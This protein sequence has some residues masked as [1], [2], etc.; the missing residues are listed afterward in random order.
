VQERDGRFLAYLKL[1]RP[2]A[3]YYTPESLPDGWRRPFSPQASDYTITDFN[4]SGERYTLVRNRYDNAVNF[5]DHQLGRLL[6]HLDGSGLAKDTAIV[7]VADHGEAWGQRG[8]FAHGFQNYEEFLEV[9]LIVHRPGQTAEVD[10]RMVSLMDV[11][12]TVLDLLGLPPYANHQGGSLLEGEERH[13]FWADSNSAARLTTLQLGAWKYTENRVTAEATLFDM[14][15]DPG[16]RKNLA[17]DPSAGE[18]RDALR[19]L[20][21]SGN[22]QQLAWAAA[23]RASPTSAL[24]GG[25]KAVP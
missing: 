20:L 17:Y 22:R 6:A 3:P 10:D 4:P 23:L 18:R 25:T 12:P 7:L 14:A 19:Y 13:V 9:P 1:F 5:V 21:H 16:E 8:W 2:H 11:A 15:S 24:L